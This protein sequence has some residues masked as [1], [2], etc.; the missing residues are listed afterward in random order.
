MTISKSLPDNKPRTFFGNTQITGQ[1][2]H[3]GDAI[4]S[5]YSHELYRFWD[6]HFQWRWRFTAISRTLARRLADLMGCRLSDTADGV[7]FGA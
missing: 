1:V 6:Q 7:T 2:C 3:C 5:L 4:F